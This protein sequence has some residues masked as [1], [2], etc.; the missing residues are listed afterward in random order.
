MNKLAHFIVHGKAATYIAALLCIVVGI[1]QMVRDGVGYLQGSLVLLAYLLAGLLLVR[2]GREL[3]L[4]GG[5]SSFAA[6][7]YYLGCAIAPR[8]SVDSS[9][10]MAFLLLPVALY[11]LLKTYRHRFSMGLYFLAFVLVGVACM[12]VPPLLW[13]MPLLVLCG[14]FMESLNGRT[15]LAALWGL[16]CPYWVM[17][18]VLFLTDRIGEVP[19]YLQSLS[20]PMAASRELWNQ[21]LVQGQWVWMLLLI[22]PTSAMVWFNHAMRL[23]ANASF[24]FIATAFVV[25]TIAALAIPGTCLALSPSLLLLGSLMGSVQFM[26]TTRRGWNIYLF[27]LLLLWVFLGGYVYGAIL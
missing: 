2:T 20:S 11:I 8:L 18:G 27:F 21:P 16:L 5:K 25:M 1:V 26:D 3:S 7:L 12:L 22:V 13:A 19:L 14:L 23:Q 4:N 17:V 15:L 10:G 6:T 24:R 9:E